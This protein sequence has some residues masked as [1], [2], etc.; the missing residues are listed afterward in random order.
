MAAS[1]AYLAKHGVPASVEELLN[2]QLMAGN[3]IPFWE[4]KQDGKTVRIPLKP[5]YSIDSLRLVIQASCAGVGICLIPQAI[6]E[7]M[8]QRNQLL[9]LLPNVECPEGVAYLVW[10]DRKLVSARVAAFREVI[11]RQL[12]EPLVFLSAVT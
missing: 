10:A 12:D 1:P 3:M 2:H 9:G 4:F 5:K 11:I 8:E 7:P 6:L